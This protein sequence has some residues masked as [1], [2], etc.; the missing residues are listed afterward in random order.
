MTEADLRAAACNSHA[1]PP[2]YEFATNRYRACGSA[3]MINGRREAALGTEATPRC[4]VS[5][6]SNP[7]NCPEYPAALKQ[8]SR[9]ETKQG[10]S[11]TS[12]VLEGDLHFRPI[13]FNLP[14]LDLHVEFSDLGNAQVP[15][16]LAPFST[17]AAAAFSQDS[18]L[19]PTSSITLYTL[20]AMTYSPLSKGR[21]GSLNRLRSRFTDDSH[22]RTTCSS[23]RNDNKWLPVPPPA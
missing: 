16:A 19:L 21:E 4:S 8:T 5:V 7:I 1:S 23:T 15:Q 9:G 10:C 17:A 14:V 2:D 22:R 11:A 6:P 13:G 20:S 12:F 18:V 3:G